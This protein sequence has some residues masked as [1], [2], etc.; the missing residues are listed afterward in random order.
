ML[1][2][3]TPDEQKAKDLA[4]NL[5]QAYY[6]SANIVHADNRGQVYDAA[7]KDA[8]QQPDQKT[9]L[10]GDMQA[11]INGII[12][13]LNYLQQ[14]GVGT[15][16]ADIARLQALAGRE[17]VDVN[18]IGDIA[19]QDKV[20]TDGESVLLQQKMGELT[21]GTATA[22]AGSGAVDLAPGIFKELNFLDKALNGQ[23]LHY[24]EADNELKNPTQVPAPYPV[25]PGQGFALG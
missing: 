21:L 5:H 7:R 1:E 16:G 2:P 4:D 12:A 18:E 8:E 22:L 15:V 20:A 6:V 25:V 23:A 17:Y 13:R 24:G 11:Q 9:R 10:S 3:L 19:S 14:A